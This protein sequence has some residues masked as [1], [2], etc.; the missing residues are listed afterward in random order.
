MTGMPWP[1]FCLR[2]RRMPSGVSLS[3]RASIPSR[4]RLAATSRNDR[5]SQSGRKRVLPSMADDDRGK[6][7]GEYS[8]F[9]NRRDV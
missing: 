8:V 6:R 7:F 2:L 3:R 1:V 4:F 5:R 9:G